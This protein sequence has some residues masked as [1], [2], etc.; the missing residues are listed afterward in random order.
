MT[1]FDLAE[2]ERRREEGM[3]RAADARRALLAIAQQVAVSLARQHAE[4]DSDMVAERMLQD[5][6][7]YDLLQ[8]AAGSVFKS[9]PSGFRWHFV[10]IRNSR[11]VSTHARIIRVW[12]LTPDSP[13]GTPAPSA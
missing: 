2:A 1:L 3:S 6:H 9:P 5:G 13:D 8:N 11:R 7:D 4:V 12:R 10:G